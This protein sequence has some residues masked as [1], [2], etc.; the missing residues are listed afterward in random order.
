[1]SF[2]EY[3]HFL[4]IFGLKLSNMCMQDSFGETIKTLREKKHLT[5]KEAANI[6]EIDFSMLARIEK[7]ER[8]ANTLIFRRIADLFEVDETQLRI[9]ALATQIYKEA[10]K[11]E[12]A[13]DA[14]KIVLDKVK[15][16]KK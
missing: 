10:S 16:K 9:E 7:D 13:E 2:F 8:S 4:F 6:L 3:N 14:L 15:Q 5:L 12:F 11:Y 1:M